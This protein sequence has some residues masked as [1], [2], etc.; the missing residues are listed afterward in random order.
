MCGLSVGLIS[1]QGAPQL[2]SQ[3]AIMASHGGK[4]NVD[5]ARLPREKKNISYRH[6][7]K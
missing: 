4:K 6:E 5:P 2:H 7:Q 3:T 1:P